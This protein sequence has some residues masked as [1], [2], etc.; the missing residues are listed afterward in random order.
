MKI[1]D[2]AWFR[3][4]ACEITAVLPDGDDFW[5]SGWDSYHSYG[6]WYYYCPQCREKERK[7]RHE[8]EDKWYSGVPKK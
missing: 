4:D 8:A 6:E 5:Q 1:K 2:I 3:C 7:K